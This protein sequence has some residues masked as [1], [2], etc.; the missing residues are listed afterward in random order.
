MILDSANYDNNYG[1][2][3]LQEMSVSSDFA[4]WTVELSESGLFGRVI[5]IGCGLGNNLDALNEQ[6]TDLWA[7]DNNEGYLRTV[8]S[9]KKYLSGTILW[10][11]EKPP[12]ID[13]QFDS[14]FC[15]NV[16]EH[17]ED[18][19]NAMGNIAKIPNIKKGVIIVPANNH[20]YSRIDKNLGHYRRYDKK[21]LI[22][23]LSGA[24]LK[25]LEMNSF[26]KIGTLGWIGQSMILKRDTLGSRN[27]RVFDKLMPLIRRIDSFVPF[28]GLSLLAIVKK[29]S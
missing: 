18:D 22:K 8:A 15:S 7:S 13:E 1:K 16:L 10:D 26:N 25:V 28:P 12:N 14:F 19:E 3:I 2:T 29:T 27:M 9:E 24:G 4:R 20:I 5:E 11:I 21:M 17:I 23:K 6:C